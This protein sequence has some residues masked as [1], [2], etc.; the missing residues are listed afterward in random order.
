MRSTIVTVVIL[1]LNIACG[2]SAQRDADLARCIQ[3]EVNA[4]LPVSG[5][6]RLPVG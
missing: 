3:I 6:T 5:G 2:A 1:V 4:P